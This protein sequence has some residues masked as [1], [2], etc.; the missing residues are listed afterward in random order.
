VRA[1]WNIPAIILVLL[2]L[3]QKPPFRPRRDAA[4]LGLCL[5]ALALLGFLVSLAAGFSGFSV[6]PPPS[7]AG[8]AG[9]AGAV[10]LSLSSGYLEEGYFRVYLPAR[11]RA[12]PA[13]DRISFLAPVLAFG[14]CHLYEGPWG[15]VNALFAAL[16]LAGTYNKTGSL[17]GIALAHGFYNVLVYVLA[18][19]R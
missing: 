17:H 9:W 4:V 19:L 7:P 12:V 18:A 5:P 8:P 3:E 16:L 14:L 2:L 15:F 13:G 1:L 10:L 6:P 11:L